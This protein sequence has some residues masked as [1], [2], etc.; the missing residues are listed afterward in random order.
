MTSID[1][2]YQ[3]WKFGVVFT[4]GVSNLLFQ[5]RPDEAS[6]L[7]AEKCLFDLVDFLIPLL[8]HDHVSAGTLQQLLL[9]LPLAGHR[10]GGQ[11]SAHHLVLGHAQRQTSEQGRPFITTASILFQTR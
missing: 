8:V 9:R 2:K 7:R 6:R 4:D 10:H 5:H 1:M 11:N 3:I